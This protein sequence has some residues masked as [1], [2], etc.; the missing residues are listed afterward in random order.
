MDNVVTIFITEFTML[1]FS[2]HSLKV[3]NE[4]FRNQSKKLSYNLMRKLQKIA[5]N[6]PLHLTD[7]GTVA[8]LSIKRILYNTIE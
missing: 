2:Y 7:I 1:Q 8:D 6:N 5:D 3:Y 4:T